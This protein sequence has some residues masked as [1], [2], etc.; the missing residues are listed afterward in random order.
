MKLTSAT[1]A[2]IDALAVARLTRLAQHDE[3]WP[4]LEI[5]EAYL[6]KVGDSRLADLAHCPYCLSFWVA[7]GVAVARHRWP[8]GWPILSRIM[9]SS[10]VAGHLAQLA[11]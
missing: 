6:Q 3:V 8:L 5:R 7:I 1:E 9:A 11:E 4:V 10:A 2:V